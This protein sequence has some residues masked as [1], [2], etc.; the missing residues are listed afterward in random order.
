MITLHINTNQRDQI[1]QALRELA[2]RTEEN[3]YGA[4]EGED[5]DADLSDV[6]DLRDMADLIED[7]E[8]A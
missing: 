7:A 5:R 8:D 6:D 2:S 4:P 1:V 3:A